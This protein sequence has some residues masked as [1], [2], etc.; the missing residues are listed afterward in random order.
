MADI[1]TT[2]L[3]DS[4]VV[5]TQ[6]NVF[7]L[8]YAECS[9]ASTTA[10]KTVTCDNF[11]LA[12]GAMIAI[13][14]INTHTAS[15]MTLKVNSNDAKNV[16]YNGAAVNSGKVTAY[17]VYTFIYDG[18][19]FRLLGVN[20]DTN[21]DTK[22]SSTNSTSKL[23][24]VGTTTQTSAGQTGY[25]NS[26]CYASGGALYSEGTKVA[27]SGHTHTYSQVGAASA[28]HTHTYSQVGA[29][30]ASHTHSNYALSSHTHNEYAD[31]IHTHLREISIN[32][33]ANVSNQAS[34]ATGGGILN[35]TG[36]MFV[37]SQYTDG[38][39][40][41]LNL[42][43]DIFGKSTDPLGRF[44]TGFTLPV[45]NSN[46]D[47]VHALFNMNAPIDI[48]T[49]NAK[50]FTFILT[51]F[52]L[53]G[54]NDAS[55]GDEV[56]VANCIP[57]SWNQLTPYYYE[58][59]PSYHTHTYT[60]SDVGAASSAHTHSNYASTSH[61]HTSQ[62]YAVNFGTCSTASG[63]AA[64]TV[65]ITGIGNTPTNGTR[66][67][68]RFT[69]ANN[70][71]TPTLKVNSGSACKIMTPSTNLKWVAGAIIEFVYYSSSWYM[72]SSTPVSY[73]SGTNVSS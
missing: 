37:I 41:K 7:T 35:I 70:T 16:Y 29:A 58:Y 24:L 4:I 14:F 33:A 13:K 46:G 64:K 22:V 21:T 31:D 12:T 34:F 53:D 61:T 27:L 30:S 11:V 28:S 8:P 72:M 25:S 10:A 55:Q 63:T 2:N 68:V 62:N 59:A 57:I 69:Y 54:I 15:T 66:I 6:R 40:L 48:S 60:Y 3:I 65:T 50:E 38:T 36:Q 5:G 67:T 47:T 32:G 56:S 18:T 44:F 20:T 73:T 39:L 71:T 42:S 1:S 45:A 17:N 19:Y 26:S 51:N 9:T 52:N 49:S 23:F 43:A